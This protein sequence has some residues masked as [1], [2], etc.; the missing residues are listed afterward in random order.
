MLTCVH[1]GS[2]D[3]VWGEEEAEIGEKAALDSD[4]L[5]QLTEGSIAQYYDR[6]QVSVER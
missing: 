4:M 3:V 5:Q 6:S 1:C 2:T